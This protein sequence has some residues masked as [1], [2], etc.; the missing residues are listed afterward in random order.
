MLPPPFADVHPALFAMLAF[1][2]LLSIV[3]SI[4][5]LV[6]GF[7]EHVLWGLGMLCCNVTQFVFLIVHF[8]KAWR[9]A[10]L[11]LFAAGVM[12]VPTVAIV[13]QLNAAQAEM[14]A[15]A[16]EQE[17]QRAAQAAKEAAER[18]A[19][20]PV[21][22][23]VDPPRVE[24]PTDPVEPPAPT[25]KVPAKVLTLTGSKRTAYA[26]LKESKAWTAIRW[27]NADV[28]DDDL[29][30]LHGL[31]ELLEL[32]LSDTQVTDEGLHA[33][34][35]SDKLAVLKLARTAVTE[36][37]F[38]EHVLPIESLTTLDIRGTKIPKKSG[39]EWKA[40]APGRTL[41]Q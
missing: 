2:A 12:A 18:P 9:P 15:K 33:L 4:W 22:D 38:R 24:L 16:A 36:E 21:A 17:A 20:P 32:D 27:A 41:L 6:V 25:V 31:T 3:G 8:D 14:Q 11:S 19:T 40:A 39:R 1:G 37:G 13:I 26:K 30:V 23:P 7:K 10:L 29:E 35:D 28:T 34:E 5:F